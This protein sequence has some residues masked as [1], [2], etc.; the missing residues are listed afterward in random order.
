M[1]S[2]T[3]TSDVSLTTRMEKGTING[4]IHYEDSPI[5][6]IYVLNTKAYKTWEERISGTEHK[7]EKM[8]ALLK[9]CEIKKKNKQK[10]INI[11]QK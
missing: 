8:H 9:K 2:Q 4:K 7:I 11:I 3:E 6:N 5:L 10:N 1:K